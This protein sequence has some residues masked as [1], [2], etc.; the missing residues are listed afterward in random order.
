[1]SV[2]PQTPRWEGQM[3]SP[4]AG[5]AVVWLMFYLAVLAF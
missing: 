1:M 5:I 4:E 3:A 2:T